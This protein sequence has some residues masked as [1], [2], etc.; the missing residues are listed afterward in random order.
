[1]RYLLTIAYDGTNYRGWQK[2]IDELT[3]QQTIEEV[4]SQVLNTEIII[5][6][7]GR[8]D[9]G[10]HAYA[11]HAHFDVKKQVDVDKLKYSLNSLLPNDI[12][13]TNIKQ[14]ADDFH[15]RFSA[16]KKLYEYVIINGERSPFMRDH[17]L[18]IKTPLDVKVLKEN[19]IK[20]RGTHNFKNFTTKSDDENDYVREIYFTDVYK[21][22]DVIRLQFIGEGF[23]RSQIRLMVGALLA[24]ALNKLPADYIDLNL[25]TEA[26][27][28]T[29]SEKAPARGLYLLG[30]DY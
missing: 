2:Q 18:F 4:L 23:M 12:V 9:A 26:Q 8:T 11:Q 6:G 20:F 5:H 19:I 24:I 17:A 10:V 3:I 16:K 15:A 1:M 25:N 22:G 29:I 28:K 27:R 7:S 13:I 14:V 21:Q 30:V